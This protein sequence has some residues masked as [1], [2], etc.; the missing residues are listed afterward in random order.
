MKI[1]ICART[2]VNVFVYTYKKHNLNKINSRLRVDSYL[3]RKKAAAAFHAIK[4]NYSTKFKIPERIAGSKKKKRTGVRI[5][6]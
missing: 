4:F 6:G 5:V 3:S 2:H 1:Q